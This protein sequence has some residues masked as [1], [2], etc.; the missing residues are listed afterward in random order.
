[1]IDLAQIPKVNFTQ[2]DTVRLISTAY[3]DEP[4]MAPLVD[5]EDELRFLEQ[6]E[7]LTSSRRN[8]GVPLPAGV[9]PAELLSEHDGYGWTYVNAAFC[10]TRTGGNR[11]N[12]ADRGAWYATWGDNAVETALAE[13]TFHL[14]RELEATGV[15]DNLT[16]YRELLAGFSADFHDLRNVAATDLFVSDPSVAYPLGQGLAQSIFNDGGDGVLY[17]SV[18]FESGF[19]LAAFRPRLVQNVRQGDTWQLSWAGD[20]VPRVDRV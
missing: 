15:F 9:F 17:S 19:C 1:M 5:D 11:F 13:V 18:R 4:A 6:I 8:R 7:G 3:I 2:R 10:Y 14:T 16:S 20:A 12:G